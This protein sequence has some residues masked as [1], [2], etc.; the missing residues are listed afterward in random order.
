[1]ETRSV[2]SGPTGLF[3]ELTAK[4]QAGYLSDLVSAGFRESLIQALTEIDCASYPLEQWQ[5]LLS[6]VLR[7]GQRAETPEQAKQILLT[8][9]QPEA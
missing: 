4:T 2:P 7:G 1:M 3:E 6:Y 5:D 9:L 8:E